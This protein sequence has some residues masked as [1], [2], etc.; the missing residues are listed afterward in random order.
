LSFSLDAYR[1]YTTDLF[2]NFPMDPTTGTSSMVLNVANMKSEGVD[3][4][5]STVNPFGSFQLGTTLLLTYNNNWITKTYLD[6][7][8]PPSYVRTGSLSTLAGTIAFP[9][10][11][12]KWGGLDPDTGEPMGYL[13]GEP[14]KDYRTISSSS[15]KLEDLVFHGS[16]R[17]LYFGA[18][19][20][21]LDYKRWSLSMN[22][23][24]QLSYYFRRTGLDYGEL[25]SN[26]VGHADYYNRWQHPGDEK[27]THVP[28][29][30]YPDN[31]SASTFY[32][33]SEVLM[34]KGDHIRL[35]DIRLD[36]RMGEVANLGLRSAQAFIY[37]QNIGVLWKATDLDLDPVTKGGIPS[38]R[39]VSVG[40]NLSF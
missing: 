32:G 28:S 33:Y 2:D 19:R 1:K 21:T 3:I 5:I 31:S 36:F 34:E 8:S 14:S 29:M 9:A 17:P 23:V 37:A 40:L 22:I 20:N 30:Q 27:T 26:S 39:S 18:F 4:K 24:F 11:S 12:Y 35:Q 16:A 10:Y 38:P 6:Y 25:F 7:S 15:T 13:D